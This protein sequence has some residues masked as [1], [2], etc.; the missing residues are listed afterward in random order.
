MQQAELQIKQAEVQRKT[1][2]DQADIQIR[3]AEQQRKA[4]KIWQM[5]L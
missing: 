1:Q 4:Q 5:G 2:K 3:Q